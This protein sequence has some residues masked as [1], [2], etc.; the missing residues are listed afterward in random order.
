[1]SIAYY[2]AILEKE[3]DSDFGVFF[4]DLPGVV[5]AGSDVAEA[6]RRAEEALQ[7]HVDGLVE[8]GEPVP[9]PGPIEAIEHD[10]EVQRLGVALVRVRLPGRAKRVNLTLDEHLLSEIDAAAA[11]R[12]D[13]RSGFLAEAARRLIRAMPGHDKM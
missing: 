7:L 2:P 11:A 10:P 3:A 12:G 13:S 9:A 1:M 6:L 8:F 5:T 4:P